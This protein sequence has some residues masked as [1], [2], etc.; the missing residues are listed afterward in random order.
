MK[1]LFS[2]KNYLSEEAINILE[3]VVILNVSS[4]ILKMYEEYNIKKT[5]TFESFLQ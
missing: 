5:S 2:M 3:A 1:I 4:S